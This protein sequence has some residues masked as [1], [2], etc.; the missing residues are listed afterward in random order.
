MLVRA[1]SEILEW[2]KIQ[3]DTTIQQRKI[4]AEKEKSR[5]WTRAAQ[6]GMIERTL[7]EN[8]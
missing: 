2:K 8:I 7:V 5:D 3:S 1:C 4:D 6:S